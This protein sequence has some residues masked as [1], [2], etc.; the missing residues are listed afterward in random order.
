MP[1]TTPSPFRLADATNGPSPLLVLEAVG[2]TA[3]VAALA[4]GWV[5]VMVTTTA[6][7]LAAV[8]LL[9]RVAPREDTARE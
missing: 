9:A 5:T 2:V 1:D 4:F 6:P 7:M 3:V 8:S